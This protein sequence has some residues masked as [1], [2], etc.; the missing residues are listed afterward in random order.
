MSKN[1]H[2]L[3]QF[4]LKGFVNDCGQLYYYRKNNEAIKRGYQN[5]KKVYPS[6]IYYEQGLNTISLSSFGHEDIDLENDVFMEKDDRYAKAF[7]DMKEKY[8]YNV[9]EIPIQT[10]ADIVEFVLGLYWRVP[11]RGER[12]SALIKKDGL[13]TGDLKLINKITNH[14]Y[15]D[16]EIPNIINDILSKEFNQKAIMPIFYE[17]VIKKHDWSNL[18]EKFFIF[19]TNIPLL[20]G[21]IPY[22]PLKSENKRN[23]ILEEFVIPLDKNHILI[24]ATKKPSYLETNLFHYI[25]LCIIDGASEKISC[26]DLEYLKTEM[27][28]SIQ[29]INNLNACGI[30]DFKQESLRPLLEFESTFPSLEEFYKDFSARGFGQG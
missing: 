15:S 3:P 29:R 14:Y 12:L 24:Y 11:G 6:G 20:I 5:Y 30:N 21:D 7:I 18:E 22:I 16:E 26:N 19:E 8:N 10:K 4:Y 2:Y 13:L 27:H 17:E 1:H 9:Y 28:D 23:K 25:A